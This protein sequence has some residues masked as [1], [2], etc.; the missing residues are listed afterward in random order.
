[1][2]G[3][4][5]P[6]G[7]GPVPPTPPG[8]TAANAPYGNQY[9]APPGYG[10]GPPPSPR[11]AAIRPGIIP[12][13][14]LGTAEMLD[15]SFAAIRTAP[16]A[17]LGVSAIVMLVYQGIFLLLNY[18]VLQPRTTTSFDGAASRDVTDAAAR[19]GAA[20]IATAVLTSITVLILTGVMAAI[21]G[22][23]IVGRRVTWKVAMARLR[24][25]WWPLL[26]VVAA[27]TG[28]VAGTVA[29]ALGP[30][31]AAAAAGSATGG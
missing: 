22:D 9:G 16:L 4:S 5:A 8:D 7:A 12:L 15:G 3:W 14:P 24:P 17:S 10:Y 25:V 27:V 6:E 13:R 20:Y 2:T 21:V 30:G 29:V 23:R 19:V 28:I 26:R 1:M 18:T 31:I 11:P